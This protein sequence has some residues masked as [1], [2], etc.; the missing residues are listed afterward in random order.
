MTCRA[1]PA[2]PVPLLRAVF[3]GILVVML[4]ATVTA[5]LDYSILEVPARI[6]GDAWFHATLADAYCG[7]LTF[8]CWVAYREKTCFARAAWLVAILL[9]GNIAMAG[10]ML[11]LLWRLP[12]DAS[13]ADIL[14]RR[15]EACDG[16]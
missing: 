4:V 5:S 15:E 8:W 2:R 11:A 13:P 9:L 3:A 7:F 14:L 16:R 10:Y 1:F 6:G 12:A